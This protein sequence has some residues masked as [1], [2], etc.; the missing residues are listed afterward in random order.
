MA[1]VA[2]RRRTL[3]SRLCAPRTLR[4]GRHG[5]GLPGDD[6]ARGRGLVEALLHCLALQCVGEQKARSVDRLNRTGM[7]GRPED[8]V[9]ASLPSAVKG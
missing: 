2:Q 7:E 3:R 9:P 6:L 1:K 5:G 8:G 4:V